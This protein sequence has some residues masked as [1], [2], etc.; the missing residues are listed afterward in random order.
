MAS[1]VKQRLVT[2]NCVR[3]HLWYPPKPCAGALF[4]S[5]VPTVLESSEFCISSLVA[6]LNMARQGCDGGGECVVENWVPLKYLRGL[7]WAPL[8]CLRGFHLHVCYNFCEG[9]TVSFVNMFLW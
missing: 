2:R 6:E 5:P 4:I 8:K 9:F 1:N 7:H 3:E